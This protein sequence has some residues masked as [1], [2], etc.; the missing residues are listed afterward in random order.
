MPQQRRQVQQQQQPILTQQQPQ[1]QGQQ[2]AM[3]QINS[4]QDIMN[5]LNGQQPVTVW[6]A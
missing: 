3:P 1:Q 6:V 4:F 5:L 2:Q